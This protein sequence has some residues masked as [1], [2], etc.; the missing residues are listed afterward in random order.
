MY[1]IIYL[2]KKVAAHRSGNSH[3]PTQVIRAPYIT[4]FAAL[5][6]KYNGIFPFL[7]GVLY[8]F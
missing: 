3:V 8:S 6:R 1:D 2:Q 4:A 7:Q 5:Q